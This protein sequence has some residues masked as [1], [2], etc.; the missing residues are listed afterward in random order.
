[1]PLTVLH[2]EFEHLPEILMHVGRTAVT[3]T[4][5]LTTERCLIAN[6][7]ARRPEW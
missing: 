5:R 2:I 6:C 1:M 4:C 7:A 3:M